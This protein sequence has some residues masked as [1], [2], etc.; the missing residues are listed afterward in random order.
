MTIEQARDILIDSLSDD[1]IITEY[2]EYC[3]YRN[4]MDGIV[5]S[6]YEF[7]EVM[8]NFTP[9]ELA[10]SVVYGEFNPSDDWFMFNGYGN[11]QSFRNSIVFDFF[12]ENVDDDYIIRF[13]EEYKGEEDD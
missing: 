12:A 11:L 1:E 5:Y 4:D 3:E 8:A 10:S 13:A 7:D 6:M 9:M 2:N